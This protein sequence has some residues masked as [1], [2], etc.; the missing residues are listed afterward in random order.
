MKCMNV[1]P[2]IHFFIFCAGPSYFAFQFGGSL[3]ITS[4]IC[5]FILKKRVSSIVLD[6][7]HILLSISVSPIIIMN[8]CDLLPKNR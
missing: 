2:D 5:N 8:V 6:P 3:F 4:N 7:K 1:L